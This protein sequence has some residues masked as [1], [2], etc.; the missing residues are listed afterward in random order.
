MGRRAAAAG[1][2]LTDRLVETCGKGL[3]ELP[4]PWLIRR[5]LVRRRA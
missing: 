1:R 5:G 4:Y 3:V 2:R